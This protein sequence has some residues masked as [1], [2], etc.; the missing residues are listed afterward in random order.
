MKDDSIDDSDIEAD[1]PPEHRPSRASKWAIAASLF[2]AA[3][4]MGLHVWRA[5]IHEEQLATLRAHAADLQL[6]AP[7]TVQTHRLK[8]SA[9]PTVAATLRLHRPDPPQLLD[10]YISMAGSPFNTFQITVDKKDAARVLQIRRV[11][12]DSNGDVRL[13]W[14]SSAFGPGEYQFHLEGYDRRGDVVSAGWV[15][16]AIE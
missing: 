4:A 14:N 16:M 6:R 1:V 10:L 3:A 8:P 7:G 12:R 15:S 5:G 9:M 2:I 13:S 11:L